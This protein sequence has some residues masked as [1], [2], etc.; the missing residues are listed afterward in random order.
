[1]STVPDLWT[2]PLVDLS[3]ETSYG[4]DVIE[5]ADKVLDQPPLE[6]QRWLAVH[7]GELLPDGRPRFRTVLALA[8]RQYGKTHLLRV[9]SLYW[10]FV[11]SR[12]LTLAISSML[13]L[14]RDSHR[15]CCEVANSNPHLSAHLGRVQYANGEEELRTA[16]GARYMIAAATRNAG[17]GLSV[18]RLVFDDCWPEAATYATHAVADAQIVAMSSQ[19]RYL[20]PGRDDPQV[21]VFEWS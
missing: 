21:G 11:E 10:M 17:R 19:R 4:F 18:S 13:S 6:W 12:P 20:D 2:P 8:D 9:L 7:M 1:M 15:W 14:A 5:F 16:N 3:P